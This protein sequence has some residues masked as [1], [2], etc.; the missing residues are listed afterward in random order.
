MATK[1]ML[2]RLVRLKV[3]AKQ[4]E[5]QIKD[6]QEAIF[7]S[8]DY[9]EIH[10]VANLGMIKLTRRQNYKIPSNG[11]LIQEVGQT[12]FN[13]RAKMSASEVKK[14]VGETGFEALLD[15]GVILEGKASEY[16]S[17]TVLAKS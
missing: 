9:P 16:Y 8:E 10:Q 15:K 2:D 7:A 14:A 1:A 13:E 3:R 4:I 5:E 11:L 12:T 17:V 6:V